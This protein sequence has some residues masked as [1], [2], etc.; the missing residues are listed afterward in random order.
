[1]INPDKEYQ[2]NNILVFIDIETTG[3]ERSKD[4]V[5][6]VGLSVTDLQ[7]N[8]L[9]TWS[10]LVLPDGWRARL[11]GNEYVWN[12]HTNSGL[13]KELD[14]IQNEAHKPSEMEP[15]VVAWMAYRWLTEDMGLVPGVLPSCGNSVSFDREMLRET[16][17]TLDT[18]FHY[19]N[20]DISTVKE[21]CRRYNRELYNSIKEQFNKDSTAHRVKEDIDS[22]I[23]ELKIYVDN[24]LFVPG[25]ALDQYMELRSDQ[26]LVIPGMEALK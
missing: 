19:R 1:M 14:A 6:E 4:K 3:L 18:F 22:S 20:I 15:P 9:G 23:R 11:A 21:L 8:V 24:F 10:S 17:I 7:M 26:Q 2:E 25:N 16:M 12:M 5:L 13:I